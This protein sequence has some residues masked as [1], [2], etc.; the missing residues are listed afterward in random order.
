M[1]PGLPLEPSKTHRGEN[2]LVAS[3]LIAAKHRSVI[4]A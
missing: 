4:L 3:M 2:F 1:T